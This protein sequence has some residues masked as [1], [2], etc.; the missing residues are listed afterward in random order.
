MPRIMD[1]E[2]HRPGRHM[3]VG[4]I[5]LTDEVGSMSPSRWPNLARRLRDRLPVRAWP[6]RCRKSGRLGTQELARAFYLYEG[7]SGRDRTQR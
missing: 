4:H 6:T 7:R 3:P 5:T 2:M 1:R